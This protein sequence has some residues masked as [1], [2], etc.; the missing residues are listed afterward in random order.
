MHKKQNNK[1]QGRINSEC[2]TYH[3][4]RNM[5]QKENKNKNNLQIVSIRI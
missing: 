1:K 4:I 3:I 2:P 5:Y